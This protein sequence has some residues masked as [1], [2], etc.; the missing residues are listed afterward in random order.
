MS[1]PPRRRCTTPLCPNPVASGRCP[2]CQAKADARYERAGKAIYNTARW[3]RLSRR[4]LDERP[5]CQTRGCRARSAEVDHVIAIE[6]G[7]D[8]WDETNLAAL[9]SPCHGRKT[10]AEVAARGGPRPARARGRRGRR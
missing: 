8:P 3:R 2:A 1:N 6:D 10:R 5:I 9:C 4:V 7:G